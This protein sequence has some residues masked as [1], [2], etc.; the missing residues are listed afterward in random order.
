MYGGCSVYPADM[1]DPLDDDDDCSIGGA[2]LGGGKKRR[3]S[4]EQVKAL[5]KNFEVENKLEP[6]R[7]ARLAHELGLQP[8]QV[9]VWFQNRRARWKTKT[10]ER[11][12]GSLK[13]SYDTLRVDYDSLLRD[14]ETLLAQIK[15]LKAKLG[16][17]AETD[18]T[19]FSSVKEEPVISESDNTKLGPNSDELPCLLYSKDGSSD[20]DS[21]AILN[22]E[23]II[24]EK[25]VSMMAFGSSSSMEQTVCGG[26]FFGDNYHQNMLK[27]EEESAFLE[28]PC[29]SLFDEEQAPSLAW[30]YS[31]DQQWS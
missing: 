2:Q 4:T 24:D 31:A 6:E 28:E 27:M 3:L 21:S 5:E 17:A 25:K 9:A 7:K 11:D 23:Q 19:S 12:Y 30:Y 15:E 18:D 14:K 26:V 1:M 20:S 13:A 22:D 10:L 16:E 8:R 29:S